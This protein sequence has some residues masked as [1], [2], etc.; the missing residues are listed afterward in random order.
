MLSIFYSAS[1]AL[2]PFTDLITPNQT[3]E[4]RAMT[5]KAILEEAR[6]L[7][8]EYDIAYVKG[9]QEVIL[10]TKTR[11]R[12]YRVSELIAL[13]LSLRQKRSRVKEVLQ[14]RR[15]HLFSAGS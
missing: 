13:I 15:P 2:S 12:I 3:S 5:D 10:A 4:L 8:L 14:S 7:R 1:V 11:E 6:K 9:M